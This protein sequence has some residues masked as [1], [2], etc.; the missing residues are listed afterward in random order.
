[1]GKA[2]HCE[3]EERDNKQELDSQK[4][5]WVLSFSLNQ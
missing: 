3:R 1:L 2:W 4:H 5:D